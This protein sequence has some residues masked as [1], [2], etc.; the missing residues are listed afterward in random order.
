VHD[1]GVAHS[2]DEAKEVEF[3]KYNSHAIELSE[4]VDRE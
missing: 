2:V 4:G 3:V 1:A